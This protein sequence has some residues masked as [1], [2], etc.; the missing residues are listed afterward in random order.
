MLHSRRGSEAHGRTQLAL[1]GSY[2]PPVNV[3]DRMVDRTLLHR[4]AETV[5]QHFLRGV[6]ERL[7]P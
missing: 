1:S 7:T 6:A 3:L 4:V 2:D 5:A